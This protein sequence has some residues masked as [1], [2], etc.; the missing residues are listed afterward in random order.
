MDSELLQGYSRY[1]PH[2]NVIVTVKLG[3]LLAVLMTV[4]LIHFPVSTAREC[5]GPAIAA[6]LVTCRLHRVVLGHVHPVFKRLTCLFHQ[7][8][9]SYHSRTGL[10]FG[11]THDVACSSPS[12]IL[13]KL[14][15]LDFLFPACFVFKQACILERVNRS[16]LGGNSCVV[17]SLQ[18]QN[19]PFLILQEHRVNR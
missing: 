9:L 17:D 16:Q 6:F 10:V 14:T 11:S 13:L 2:D 7:Q 19:G 1:L 12:V 3:I 5:A 18:A 4:P 8:Q 15:W